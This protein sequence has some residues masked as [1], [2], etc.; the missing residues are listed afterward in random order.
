MRNEVIL[1]LDKGFKYI[2]EQYDD[3]Y[4]FCE[5]IEINTS[6]DDE[7]IQVAIKTN[8]KFK[9][10]SNGIHFCDDTIL[11]GLSKNEAKLLGKLL[12]SIADEK[13]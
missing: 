2:K 5:D 11:I 10:K 4:L 12:I 1:S 3:D 8:E 9:P 7:F 6:I 13:P